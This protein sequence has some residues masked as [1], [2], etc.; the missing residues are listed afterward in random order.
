[1]TEPAARWVTITRFLDAPPSRVH[2]AWSDP[3]EV[4]AWFSRT[5]EGS[6]AVGTRSTL[7]WHDRRIPLDVLESDPPTRFRFRWAW[8]PDSRYTTEVTVDLQPYGYGTRLNLKDGPFDLAVDGVI[9]AYAEALEGWGEALTNLRA[10]VDYSIDL[11][12]SRV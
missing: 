4:T 11:R 8:L 10:R 5:V 3:E 6:L 12:R 9:D 2:R 7:V 1:M